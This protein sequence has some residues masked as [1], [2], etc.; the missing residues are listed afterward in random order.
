MHVADMGLRD[1]DLII[2][3]VIESYMKELYLDEHR[4][5]MIKKHQHRSRDEEKSDR[6]E[7]SYS[8]IIFNNA[9]LNYRVDLITLNKIN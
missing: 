8:T 6:T 3:A 1:I 2:I 5:S 9:A 7:K 4:R